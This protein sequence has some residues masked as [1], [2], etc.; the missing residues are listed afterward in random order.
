MDLTRKST[1]KENSKAW[2][3]ERYQAVSGDAFLYSKE[4]SKFVLEHLDLLPAKAKV[5]DIACGEGRHAVALAAKGYDVTAMDFSAI[6]MERAQKLAQASGVNVLFK[7]LDLDFFIPELLTFDAIIGVDF[8]PPQTLL[9][10]LGRGLKQGGH[11]LLETHLV[12]AS[13]HITAVETFECF[14]PNEL[15]YQ[16]VPSQQ[17]T[18]RILHYSELG[19]TAGNKVYFVAK[20]TQLL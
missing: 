3:D 8:K 18:F 1:H 4:P 10:N 9:K 16:F 11:L 12:E 15:L 2:W 5:L 6:A 13:R 7:T 14:K 17:M 20:K 19:P